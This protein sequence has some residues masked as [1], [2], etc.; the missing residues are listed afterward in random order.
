MCQL[1]GYPYGR[2]IYSDELIYRTGTLLLN[3]P[4]VMVGCAPKTSPGSGR[5]LLGRDKESGVVA[6]EGGSSL[7]PGNRRQ[8]GIP[9]TGYIDTAPDAPY[10]C[11]VKSGLCDRAGPLVALECSPWG[12]GNIRLASGA[13][14]SWLW[15]RVFKRL[16]PNLC[17]DT[18]PGSSRCT[19]ARVEVEVPAPGGGNGAVW[20]PLCAPPPN[21]SAFNLANLA[22][23][24]ALGLTPTTSVRYMPGHWTFDIPQGPVTTDGHFDP[25][26]YA[27]WANIMG[28]DPWSV[29]AVQDL[30]LNVTSSPCAGG[31]LFA[32]V[33]SQVMR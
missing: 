22:C 32:M 11:Q 1:L 17:N 23:R 8:L 26:K 25:S 28:G 24:Q 16:E 15:S 5:R 30:P 2:H 18:T 27:A 29:L 19:Y 13:E 33:C 10:E 21:V 3:V 20:A 14:Y 31:Q 6:G 4:V 7:V 12:S 9:P